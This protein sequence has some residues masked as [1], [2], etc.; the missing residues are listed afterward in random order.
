MAKGFKIEGINKVTNNLN[1]VAKQEHSSGLKGLL[2]VALMLRRDMDK[3]LPLIPVDTGNLR[4]SWFT[5]AT[6][7]IKGPQVR[8]GF[9]AKYA[10]AVHEATNKNFRRPRSGAK[11]YEEALKR[12][13]QT[14]LTI[15]GKE[16][17]L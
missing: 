8:A 17:K 7:C 10:A 4:Q 3:T 6:E 12:N 14:T 1:K 2:E 5:N 11:F 9:S 15:L 13:E 16:T